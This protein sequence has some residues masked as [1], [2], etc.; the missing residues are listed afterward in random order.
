MKRFT[1]VL[2]AASAAVVTL[3]AAGNWLTTV[4]KTDGGMRMGNP[5]A[6]V[7]LIEFV[8]YTCIHCANFTREADGALKLALVQPGKMSLEV[9]H[10]IR[11]P[12][13]LTATL[14][15][16]CGPKERF[17]LNHNAFMLSHDEWMAKARSATPA[18]Q[19]RW[20]SGPLGARFRAVASDLGFYK[21]MESRGYSRVEADQCLNDED[22]ARSLVAQ[23]QADSARYGV[24]GTPS[25]A[26]DGKLLEGVHSWSALETA[27]ESRF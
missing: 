18:Q 25:F 15:A 7:S 23:S 20:S 10:V 9:R 22:A 5:A 3:A 11:D 14:L 17:F 19:Q 1:R 13:D 2:L 27:L 8:S 26:V 12:V 16:N 6:K 4:A 21:T 24:Q